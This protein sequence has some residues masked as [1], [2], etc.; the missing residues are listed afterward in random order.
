[1]TYRSIQSIAKSVVEDSFEVLLVDNAS[2]DGSRDLFFQLE[3]DVSWFRYFYQTDNKGFGAAC[4]IGVRQSRGDIIIFVNPDV[5]LQERGIDQFIR[6]TFKNEMCI[7]APRIYYPTGDSQANGGS[8]STLK[9]YIMQFLA[10]GRLVRSLG[11]I[12]IFKK[13]C[14]FIPVLKKT[15]IGAYLSNFGIAN[16][17]EYDWVS[18]AFMILRKEDFI[19]SKGFDEE[20]FL[21]CEDEDL[22]LRLKKATG[23]KIWISNEYKVIHDQGASDRQKSLIYS[24][25]RRERLRSNIYF[26]WKN[27]DKG[28]AY[29]LLA[30]YILALE[31]Q[32]LFYLVT[33]RYYLYKDRSS[34]ERFLMKAILSF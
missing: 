8:A 27:K 15:F 13:I 21:Y 4:N 25:A 32:A 14:E 22:C 30:F 9:T 17:Q 20:F 28:S 6:N 31:V 29:S 2:R 23:K 16:S 26:L 19:R 12:S 18:G 34:A 33:F 3:K 10:L 1:M 7:L 5:I 11:L 24:K